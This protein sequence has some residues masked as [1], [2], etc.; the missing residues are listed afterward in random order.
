MSPR[1]QADREHV[2][3]LCEQVDEDGGRYPLLSLFLQQH[4]LDSLGSGCSCG[5]DWYWLE[6]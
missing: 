6:A 3:G 2:L 1:V 4:V 5:E